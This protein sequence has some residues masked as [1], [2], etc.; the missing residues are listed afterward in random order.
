LAR[1]EFFG[2]DAVASGMFGGGDDHGVVEVETVG[3]ARFDDAPNGTLGSGDGDVDGEGDVVAEFG[4]GGVG[5]D[6]DAFE[7][8]GPLLGEKDVD[9][10]AGAI[11][12]A[13]EILDGLSLLARGFGKEMMASAGEAVFLQ[14]ADYGGVVA[15]L[16]FAGWAV[17]GGFEGGG[18]RKWRVV[19]IGKVGQRMRRKARG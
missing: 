6:I 2:P 8:G 5:A 17:D 10:V 3:G 13:P 9:D 14:Q 19:R 16:L 15:G 18:I 1:I 4:P 11:F 7:L 12:V